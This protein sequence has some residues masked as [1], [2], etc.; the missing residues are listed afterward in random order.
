[1]P[2]HVLA[3]LGSTPELEGE[4]LRVGLWHRIKRGIRFHEWD[5]WNDTPEKAQKADAE[6]ER[7]KLLAAERQRRK[8][9]KDREAVT[10]DVTRDSGPELREP[11]TVS[12]SRHAPASVTVTRPGDMEP[13]KAQLKP[14]P[15]TRDISVTASVTSRSGLDRPDLDL[16]FNQGSEGQSVSQVEDRNA[17]A[18]ARGK[19]PEPVPYTWEFRLQ[20]Q[21]E[22]AARDHDDV[23][24]A[25]ADGITAEVLARSREPVP[26]PWGY[27]RKAIRGEKDP[28]SRWLSARPPKPAATLAAFDPAPGPH[29]FQKDPETGGCTRCREPQPDKIHRV[30]KA[31]AS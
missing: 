13:E 26:H 11:V 10:R 27:V 17:G 19:P 3:D 21:G 28:Y 8:R 12:R 31:A 16:D 20:V 5:L 1:M 7:K 24:D 2:D 25:E 18:R 9:A 15:V 22:M 14:G 23:T 6:A 4:L 29:E 30:K